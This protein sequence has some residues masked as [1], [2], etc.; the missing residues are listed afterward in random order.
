MS[1][2]VAHY[3]QK[4]ADG[5]KQLKVATKQES[6]AKELPKK[7]FSVSLKSSVSNTPRWLRNIA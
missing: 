6:T 3:Q 4:Q 2:L 7:L 1:E 5:R